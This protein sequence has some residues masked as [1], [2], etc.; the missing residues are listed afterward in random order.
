MPELSL[1][2]F[3]TVK[4]LAGNAPGPIAGRKKPHQ[5]K[6][7]GLERFETGGVV[8][9]DLDSDA[10]K[11]VAA[12]LDIE[13]PGPVVG[14]AH[15]GDVFAKTHRSNPVRAAANWDIHHH[16]VKRLGDAVLHTPLSAKDWQ[17]AHP[18]R[19]F[20]VGLAKTVA[21][22]ELIDHLGCSH[23]FKQ[24]FI[25]RR[26]VRPHQSVKA[27]FDICSQ[28]RVAVVEP[29]LR[30]QLEGSTQAVCCNLDIAGQ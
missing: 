3:A 25:S 29:G 19:Q 17:T 18:Q 21:H 8:F 7:A 20:S 2:Q 23:I 16:F 27:V 14:V 28:H 22:G 6:L 15:I 4:P 24:G 10:L 30:A 1:D 11:I 13:L 26:G 12:A 9:V 5:I